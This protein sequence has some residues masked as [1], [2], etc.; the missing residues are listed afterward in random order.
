MNR[1][2]ETLQSIRPSTLSK[3]TLALSTLLGVEAV[4]RCAVMAR[5]GDRARTRLAA[6]TAVSWGIAAVVNLV[7]L[8]HELAEERARQVA[9]GDGSDD[10]LVFSTSTPER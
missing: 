9:D 10:E 5:G 8:H 2:T 1:F 4:V 6:T 7:N 3:V